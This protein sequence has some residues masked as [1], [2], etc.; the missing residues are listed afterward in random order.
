MQIDAYTGE[1]IDTL[2]EL[3]ISDNTILIFTADNGPEALNVGETNLTVETA[4]HGSAGPWRGSLFTG[5]EGA[6]RVL[7]QCAGRIK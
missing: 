2:D 4:A 1:I 6:L 3:D 7:L 5:F